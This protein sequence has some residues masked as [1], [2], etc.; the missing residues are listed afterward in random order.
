M[1]VSTG[2][3]MLMVPARLGVLIKMLTPRRYQDPAYAEAIAA[4]LYGGLM[5]RH[6]DEVRHVV[7]ER[8]RLG[9][10]TGYVLQLLAGVG[11]TSLPALP[12]IRQHTLVLAGNDDPLIP[13]VNARIMHA[14]CPTPRCT[15]T[16]TAT[17]GCSPQPTSSAR[18]SRGSC[19]PTAART[20]RGSRLSDLRA[21]PH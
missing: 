7:H 1:L 3:G 21:T 12:L 4:E 9:S 15:S 18:S 6:P 14:C 16:T 8:E 2:T 10:R 13:T 20:P 11:W 17:S 5:R 19:S